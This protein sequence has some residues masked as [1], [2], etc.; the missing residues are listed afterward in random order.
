LETSNLSLSDGEGSAP[1][2][3]RVEFRR[4][5]LTKRPMCILAF[6][7]IDGQET[8]SVGAVAHED[9]FNVAAG[10]SE[11]LDPGAGRPIQ[12]L[13]F[14]FAA[15]LDFELPDVNVGAQGYAPV[16]EFRATK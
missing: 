14:R 3:Q 9:C 10:F 6:P 13:E 11:Q 1:R 2:V 16:S 4:M 5:S 8:T 15:R 12:K 7:S